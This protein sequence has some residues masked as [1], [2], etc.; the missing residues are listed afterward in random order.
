MRGEIK[1]RARSGIRA[2]EKDGRM[3]SISTLNPEL[4][5]QLPSYLANRGS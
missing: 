3:R 2:K 1:V 4:P 5:V